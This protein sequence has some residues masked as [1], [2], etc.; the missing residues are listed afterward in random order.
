VIGVCRKLLEEVPNL[1]SSLNTVRMSRSRKL[2]WAEHVARI[3]R[4]EVHSEF[5]FEA[6]KGR[7]HSEDVQ[8]DGDYC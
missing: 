6:M 2:R 8:V 4:L 5:C 7:D 3:R 1:Y